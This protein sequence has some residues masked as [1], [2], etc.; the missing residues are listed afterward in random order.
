[1]NM[2]IGDTNRIVERG[3][4]AFGRSASD[5]LVCLSFFSRLPLSRHGARQTATAEALSRAVDI[6]PLAALVIAAPAAAI[7]MAL[8]WTALPNP[9]LATLAIAAL[10]LAT[11]GLHEDGLADTADGF[12]GGWDRAA[13]LT[14]MH[15]SA[16]GTYGV[17]ALILS[18]TLRIAAL[19][20]ILMMFGPMTAGA[21]I[22]SAA[23][24]SR[25]AILW[26]WATLPPARGDG[27]SHSAGQ[28]TRR[29]LYFAAVLALALVLLLVVPKLG[30]L[31]TIG[32]LLLTG[33]VS[34]AIRY[35]ADDQIGGQTGDVLGATQQVSE[36]GFLLGL[37]VFF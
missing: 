19:A 31:A 15:D 3:Y 27:L 22:L 13:K 35:L 17:T 9:V 16:I 12:G 30:L 23:V 36:I 11:G 18:L 32:A 33:L 1:M 5:F 24:A 37:M 25:A 2:K 7:V 20:W 8:G 6:L 29:S 28:P 10:V 34:A 21:V 14:I 26:P 4:Q